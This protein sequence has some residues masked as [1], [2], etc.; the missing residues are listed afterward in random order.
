MAI[1]QQ[2]VKTD[3][4]K[5]EFLELLDSQKHLFP[6]WVTAL[7][8]GWTPKEEEG[9]FS[10]AI[11]PDYNYRRCVLKV[12]PEFFNSPP[13]EQLDMIRH[14]IAHAFTGPITSW[15]EESLQRFLKERIKDLTV[16]K[17][18]GDTLAGLGEQCT[19]DI[20]VLIHDLHKTVSE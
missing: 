13:D 11:W 16:V 7:Y 3:F 19:Q 12:S 15:I 20:A 8:I 2:Y 10:L 18:I 9:R 5:P 14:E 6:G 1:C 4:D 17:L